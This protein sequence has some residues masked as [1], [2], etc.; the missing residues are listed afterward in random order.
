MTY[1]RYAND[2]TVLGGDA[3]QHVVFGKIVLEALDAAESHE[4]AAAG[5]DGRSHGELRA[6]HHDG[7]EH[8]GVKIRVHAE[9]FETRPET[10]AGH[11]AVGTSHQSELLVREFI[12]QATAE[13][14]ADADVAI[15]H[16]NQIVLRPIEHAFQAVDLGVRIGRFAGDDQLGLNG[17]VFEHQ[18]PDDW[19]RRVRTRDG[20][21]KATRILR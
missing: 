4:Y 15:A 1:G 16:G 12:G 13:I 19:D 21:R 3:A 17:R 7:R 10:L 14:P 6:F 5:D 11:G 2:E 18:P 9:R 20:Q 8:T